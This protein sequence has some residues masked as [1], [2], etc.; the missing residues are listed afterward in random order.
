MIF[1]AKIQ[2]WPYYRHL[3]VPTNAILSMSQ[4]R[5]KI[6]FDLFR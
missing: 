4:R 2:N 3:P 6:E 5:L 1:P